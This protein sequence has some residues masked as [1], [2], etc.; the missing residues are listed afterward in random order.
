MTVQSSRAQATPTY[1]IYVLNLIT[2][3]K[4]KQWHASAARSIIFYYYYSAKVNEIEKRTPLNAVQAYFLVL[5]VLYFVSKKN[6]T[7]L[8]SI[9]G[10]QWDYFLLLLSVSVC[11]LF[12]YITTPTCLFEFMN[13]PTMIFIDLCE[14]M[15]YTL[16]VLCAGV[17]MH[18]QREWCVFMWAKIWE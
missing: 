3:F 4:L 5:W 12:G 15:K 6:R 10:I 1:R 14:C 7:I 9:Y 18:R 16:Y 11:P 8:W 2:W 17:E 13:F